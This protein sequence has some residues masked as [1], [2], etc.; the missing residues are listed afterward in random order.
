MSKK[1]NT[2]TMEEVHIYDEP[3]VHLPIYRSNKPNRAKA[4]KF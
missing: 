4:K 2:L 1:S 3:H